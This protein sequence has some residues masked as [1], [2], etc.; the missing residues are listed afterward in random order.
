MKGSCLLVER[1][2]GGGRTTE[3]ESDIDFG[4]R[5]VKDFDG[6]RRDLRSKEERYE[7][8]KANVEGKHN[9]KLSIDWA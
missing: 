9:A 6:G 7:H 1:G 5:D 2:D 8:V 3:T 4:G